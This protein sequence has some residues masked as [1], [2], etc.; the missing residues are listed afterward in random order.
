MTGLFLLTYMLVTMGFLLS[1]IIGNE[2]NHI[3]NVNI[4]C[5]SYNTPGQEFN[6]NIKDN[7]CTNNFTFQYPLYQI[8]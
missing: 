4:I 6:V 1:C 5:S 7:H 8:S 2:V 3:V